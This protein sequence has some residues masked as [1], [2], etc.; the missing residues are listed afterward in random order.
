[1]EVLFMNVSF[2]S[3]QKRDKLKGRLQEN[4]EQLRALLDELPNGNNLVCSLG[5][6]TRELAKKCLFKERLC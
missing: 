5:V 4:F 1:M 2:P 6:K 3:I